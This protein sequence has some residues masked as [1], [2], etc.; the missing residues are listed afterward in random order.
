MPSADFL[1][2]ICAGSVLSAL[3]AEAGGAARI[4]LC[5]NLAEGGT[6]PSYGTVAAARD[7]L[8]IAC[9]VMIRPRGGDFL[10][11]SEELD[12]MSRDI[13]LC[14]R[15]GIDGVV[16]GVLTADGA[17]DVAATR[18]LVDLA[19][20]LPVT[21]HR[22]FDM[23]VDADAALEQVIASGCQ[24][25]LTSGQ[26]Q[27]AL[28]GAAMIKHLV[29]R[30]AGRLIVMPGSG[31]RADNIGPLRAQTGCVEFHASARLPVHSAMRFRP[32]DVLLGAPGGD[33]YARWE[34]SAD[35]VQAI[36]EAADEAG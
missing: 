25:L 2:E 12:V 10:Y 3:E 18:A 30:A 5:E 15:L 4:E 11:C 16:L 32:E 22:A 29:V 35:L 21:F 17:V 20:P 36:I 1:L 13:E 33:D 27:S 23:T 7:T 28:I 31:V 34:S 9:H 8:G 19:Q 14:K 24:R 26:A 6:T